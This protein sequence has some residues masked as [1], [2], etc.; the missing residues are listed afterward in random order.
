MK[1]EDGIT[2]QIFNLLPETALSPAPSLS[3]C[4]CP[5]PGFSIKGLSCGRGDM[6]G[7]ISGKGRQENHQPRKSITSS[8]V[9]VQKQQLIGFLLPTE[10]I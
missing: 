4:I 10:L 5:K 9:S 8:I 6:Q 3:S 2:L 7:V 1:G